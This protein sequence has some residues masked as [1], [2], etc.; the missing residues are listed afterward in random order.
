MRWLLLAALSVAT[1]TAYADKLGFDPK[2]NYKMPRGNAASTGP[3]DAPI[4]I[5][6]WSD[7]ACAF[8]IRVQHTL[9]HLTRLYPGQI[10]W[11][12]RT[13]LLDDDFTLAAEAALA[14]GAQ[15]KFRPMHER[16]YALHGR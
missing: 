1:T 5:V 14:A 3:A 8:C 12:H 2:Q 15:G 9:D 13:L 7:Y 16:L 4:T 11:V 10:R 6:E